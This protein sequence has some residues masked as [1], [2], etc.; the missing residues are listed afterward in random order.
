MAYQVLLFVHWR[1]WPPAIV[2]LAEVLLATTRLRLVSRGIVLVLELRAQPVSTRFQGILLLERLDAAG[3]LV[4]VPAAATQ[5][6]PVSPVFLVFLFLLVS[7]VGDVDVFAARRLRP[8]NTAMVILKLILLVALKRSSFATLQIESGLFRASERSTSAAPILAKRARFVRT[9]PL[10][11]PGAI[12]RWRLRL[13]LLELVDRSLV[14]ISVGLLPL[15][16]QALRALR[17][18]HLL[19][20]LARRVGCLLLGKRVWTPLWSTFYA[21]FNYVADLPL[22]IDIEMVRVL[23]K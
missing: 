9:W 22:M 18:V 20:A 19:R 7:T 15:A 3:E 17:L 11:R 14:S 1:V 13:L 21:F 12:C 8:F 2:G 6:L 16:V 5:P 4:F 23:L 10:R